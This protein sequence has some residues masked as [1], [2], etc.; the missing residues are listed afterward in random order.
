MLEKYFKYFEAILGPF[1]Q[2]VW[3]RIFTLKYL[4]S[5]QILKTMRK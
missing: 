5:L 4:I 2:F 1:L 3:L